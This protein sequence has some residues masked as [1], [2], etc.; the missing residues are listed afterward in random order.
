M[1]NSPLFYVRY[2]NKSIP[3]GNVYRDEAV[4]RNY[5]YYESNNFFAQKEKR[6]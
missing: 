4:G 1:A 3:A 6:A 2:K 5:I